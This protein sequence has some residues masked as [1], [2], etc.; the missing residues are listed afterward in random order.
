[1]SEATSEENMLALNV[2]RVQQNADLD[3]MTKNYLY[4]HSRSQN[5]KLLGKSHVPKMLRTIANEKEQALEGIKD[6]IILTLK[7]KHK[8]MDHSSA[9]VF[10]WRSWDFRTKDL[11][12]YAVYFFEQLGLLQ[13][14]RITLDTMFNFVVSIQNSYNEEPPYHNWVHAVDVAQAVYTIIR[15]TRARE[16]LS[17]LD[18]FSLLVSAL[19]HDVGHPGLNNT[20]QASTHSRWAL[21]YNDVS[22]LENMHCSTAFRILRKPKNNILGSLDTEEIKEFRHSMVTNILATD[23]SQH[24]ELVTK[25]TTHLQTKPFTSSPDDRQ[26]ISTIILHTADISNSLRPLEI[27]Q[28]WSDHLQEEFLRQ[29]D[30]EAKQGLTISPFMNRSEPN[31]AKMTQGFIDYM[32]HPLVSS[33]VRFL[34]EVSYFLQNLKEN[35]KFWADITAK[36]AAPVTVQP[37]S[38]VKTSR[39]I[40][41]SLSTVDMKSTS[42]PVPQTLVKSKF[43]IGGAGRLPDVQPNKTRVEW[44]EHRTTTIDIGIGAA[45]AQEAREKHRQ[46]HQQ[47]QRISK[48]SYRHSTATLPDIYAESPRMPVMPKRSHAISASALPGLFNA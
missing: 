26:L 8:K 17:A 36:N 10:G 5:V 11:C 33:L 38:K 35:R 23:M 2:K 29:G 41:Q 32:V 7:S 1:M 21:L 22:I 37:L 46:A 14:F 28:Y 18:V 6:Q 15:S 4:A 9:N 48:K 13:Q 16:I 31:E 34:P 25:F 30:L 42:F 19:C 45:L 47:P 43:L 40:P 39:S 12:S 3:S 27:S 20:F 44:T 24:F